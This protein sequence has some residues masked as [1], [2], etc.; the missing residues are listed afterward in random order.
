M[1]IYI[2]VCVT[3]EYKN[4]LYMYVVS[5][6]SCCFSPTR[7]VY[8]HTYIYVY[9]FCK[10]LTA[11]VAA[12]LCRA[13]IA[14]GVNN[15]SVSEA[16]QIWKAREFDAFTRRMVPFLKKVEPYCFEI[17]L[18]NSRGLGSA[19]RTQEMAL[20]HEM[21]ALLHKNYP[22]HFH[23]VFATD[24]LR[25]WWGHISAERRERHPYFDPGRMATTVPLRL[26]G[27]D[28]AVAKTVHCLVILWTSA[29]AFRLPAD[30]AYIPVSSTKLED[31]DQ[32]TTEVVYKV[33][34]WSLEILCK[35]KWP[36]SD[37][38]GRPWPQGSQRARLGAVG[39]DLA[40]EFRAII[41]E[42]CVDWKWL[43]ESIG[44][45]E[46]RRYLSCREICHKC[47][48]ATT[49]RLSYRGLQYSAPCFT[50]LQSTQSFLQAVDSE[51]SKLP[52][53]DVQ[54]TALFDWM[55]CSPLGIELRANGSAL[56]E[57]I[58]AG[59]WGQ[60]RGP[61]KVR[62]GIALKRAWGDFQRYCSDNG[63]KNTQ[64]QFTA[65]TLG[66]ADGPNG[67][68]ELKAKARNCM[69][70]TQWL[71][72]VVRDDAADAHSRNRS[73]V[74]WALASLNDTF[75]TAGY[76]LSDDEAATV[77][78]CS[79]I[80]FGAWARLRAE[81]AGTKY[82]GCIPK[83]HASM[84]LLADVVST[85]RNPASYWCFSGEHM[86]GVSRRSLASQYQI[87]LDNRM[88]RSSL[89]RLGLKCKRSER[90]SSIGSSAG[91]ASGSAS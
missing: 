85:R 74:L 13:L 58:L 83:H 69:K 17:P 14:D 78:H 38:L 30:E 18:D 26:Y 86:M 47:G 8:R 66:M 70:V 27:D 56:A 75:L 29:V 88:L 54:D 77:D 81:A 1:Y 20:P 25:E 6:F 39:A 62:I 50:E 61:W 45:K 64:P 90:I 53:F 22:I 23:K 35:G 49:G 71:A 21:F 91:S 87:G 79:R 82:W 55:H 63:L 41:W 89:V 7:A 11:G 36:A 42:I 51:L 57:L 34:R 9:D 40:G 73:R 48:A 32:R 15:P 44:F 84:H 46:Q 31:T 33:V 19:N 5:L 80:L 76:W 65:A 4:R 68:P 52:G 24:N 10:V 67:L 2:Y 37:H 60:Y 12:D 3:D 28:I 59:R 16:A 72:S 43:A